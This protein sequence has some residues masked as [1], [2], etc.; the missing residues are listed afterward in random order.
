[1]ST[2]TVA[3][4]KILRTTQVEN[5][6]GVSNFNRKT[7]STLNFAQDFG[8]IVKALRIRIE[9]LSRKVE[10]SRGLAN[11]FIALSALSTMPL[12]S[13]QTAVTKEDEVVMRD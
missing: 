3:R 5:L 9:L 12:L 7:F 10:F 6:R 11:T 13:M 2:K 4:Y 8:T 1:M